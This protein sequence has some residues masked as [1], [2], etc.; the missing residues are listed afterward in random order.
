MALGLP[1][2]FGTETTMLGLMQQQ[3]LLISNLID[4]AQRH[5]GEGE[6]V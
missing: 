1:E 2:I 5:H 6:I 3:P 4:F